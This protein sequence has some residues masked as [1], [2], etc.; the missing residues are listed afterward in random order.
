MKYPLPSI[1]VIDNISFVLV[2]VYVLIVSIYCL[3]KVQVDRLRQYQSIMKAH[4]DSANSFLAMMDGSARGGG[5]RE[6]GATL[7]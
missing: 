7:S 2:W 4:S 3:A 5:I 6:S 1:S